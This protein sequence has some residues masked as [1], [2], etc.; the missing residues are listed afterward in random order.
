MTLHYR[1]KERH[2]GLVDE[3]GRLIA[4]TGMLIVDA[5]VDGARF[6]VV[7]LGGVI[8]TAANRGRG[9]GRA[10]LEAALQKAASLGPDFAIL[11][12]YANRSGLYRKLG[13]SEVTADVLVKQP[14]G[15]ARMPQQ[16][17]SRPLVPEARW[18]GGDVVVHSL[19]F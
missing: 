2:V 16:T 18:P 9:L 1:R 11:F 10:V 5:E 4:S 3:T 7:G 8:V 19:P 13:F 14:S 6:E 15:H 12:C 17:M